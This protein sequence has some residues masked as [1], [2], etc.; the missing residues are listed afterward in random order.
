MANPVTIP[1]NDPPRMPDIPPGMPGPP[2]MPEGAPPGADRVPT[3]AGV[4]AAIASATLAP[5]PEID[6]ITTTVQLPGGLVTSDR[7]LINR[8]MVR[9]LTGHDEE[10]LEIGRAHV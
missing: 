10:A 6:S 2:P 9:E 1:L 3:E 7:R 8:A 4:Q 5:V